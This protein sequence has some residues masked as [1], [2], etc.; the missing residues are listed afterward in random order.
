MSA[1]RKAVMT[2]PNH[3]HTRG[4]GR[5][6]WTVRLLGAVGVA[7]ALAATLG[8][9]GA[10]PPQARLNAISALTEGRTV[11][12][13]IEASEPVPYVTAQPDPLTVV[14]DLRNVSAAGFR[15]AI[16]KPVSGSGWAVT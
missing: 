14:I 2:K 8:A 3:R 11:T 13:V 9:A 12:V 16:T 6:A 10:A 7:A 1:E 15:S 5:E 4:L